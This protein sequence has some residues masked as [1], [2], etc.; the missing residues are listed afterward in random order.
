MIRHVEKMIV[1][2]NKSNLGFSEIFT[3]QWERG[4]INRCLKMDFRS[5]SFF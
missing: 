2:T 1:T 5:I 3:R 4:C